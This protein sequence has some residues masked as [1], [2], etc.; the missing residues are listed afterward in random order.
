M[1]ATI[2]F[3]ALQVDA[4][5]GFLDETVDWALMQSKLRYQTLFSDMRA[6][7][8][9]MSKDYGELRADSLAR[10]Y[11]MEQKID[12]SSEEMAEMR[13]KLAI[14]VSSIQRF[15]KRVLADVQTENEKV[16]EVMRRTRQDVDRK[17]IALDGMKR[18]SQ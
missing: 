17:L 13:E 15:K 9:N 6:Q 3:D 12:A 4:L 10:L 11:R 5:Q 16:T 7:F 2:A 1:G 18:I 8:A 14:E